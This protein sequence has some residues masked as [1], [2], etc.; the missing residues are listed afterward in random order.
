V[1]YQP[2]QLLGERHRGNA[3]EGTGRQE[4]GQSRKDEAIRRTQRARAPCLLVSQLPSRTWEGLPMKTRVSALLL[5]ASCLLGCSS[6]GTIGPPGPTGPKGDTGPQGIQGPT[7][8]KGDAGAQ[9]IQGPPGPLT[10][11][12]TGLVGLSYSEVSSVQP[13]PVSPPDPPYGYVPRDDSTHPLTVDLNVAS[14]SDAF[15]VSFAYGANYFGGLGNSF[16]EVRVEV[17]SANSTRYF[18]ALA[19]LIGPSFAASA[20]VMVTGLATDAYAVRLLATTGQV[21]QYSGPRHLT[22]YRV[23]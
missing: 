17:Q 3:W 7:G 23:R 9:G 11:L 14:P 16:L 15:L 1:I 5:A 4:V 22:V 13:V 12:M 19:V 18:P 6:N 10:S 8:P 21:P 20:T 2:L